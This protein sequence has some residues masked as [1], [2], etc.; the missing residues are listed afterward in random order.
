MMSSSM[1]VAMQGLRTGAIF[2]SLRVRNPSLTG[3]GVNIQHALSPPRPRL[4]RAPIHD[5][6]R[7]SQRTCIQ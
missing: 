1:L 4:L 2:L 7:L 3:F 6:P 5:T